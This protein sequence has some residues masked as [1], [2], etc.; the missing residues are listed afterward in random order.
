MSRGETESG[1]QSRFVTDWPAP[2]ASDAEA[3]FGFW[4]REGAIDDPAIAKLRLGEVVAHSLD[5]NGAISAV[6]TAVATTLPR[7]GQPMYYYRC[8]VGR[9][10]RKSRLVIALLK[11]AR[12]VLEAYA[13]ERNFPCIGIVL[14]LENAS[15]GRALRT[16]F[17]P[18][19]GF[20]YIGRSGRGRDLR[21]YY[22]DGAQLKDPPRT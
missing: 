17:W 6:C 2:S 8:F 5:D 1:A 20:T 4:Q 13:S 9:A 19:T 22:F 11:H 12:D 10:A 16:P 7:L 3:I 14:E 21:V 15:F 18:R